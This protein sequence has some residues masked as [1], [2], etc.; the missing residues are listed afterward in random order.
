MLSLADRTKN[1]WSAAYF[2]R[3]ADP[4]Q[5]RSICVKV[6]AQVIQ[7]TNG[8]VQDRAA[9]LLKEINEPDRHTSRA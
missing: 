3:H 5:D 6:L 4:R 2:Y 8:T 1:F 7:T 9:T